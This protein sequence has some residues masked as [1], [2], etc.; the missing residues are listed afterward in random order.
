MALKK[1]FNH[2]KLDKSWFINGINY[3]Q[4]LEK[5]HANFWRN[6]H[7]IYP[8]KMNSERLRYWNNYFVLCKAMFR[9]ENGLAYGNAQYLFYKQ[10]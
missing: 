1:D 10:Q 5:W 8:E 6:L 7:H 2:F 4:T 3:W 9:P